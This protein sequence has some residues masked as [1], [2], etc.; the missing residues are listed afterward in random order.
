[1]N[2]NFGSSSHSNWE[3]LTSSKLED[4]WAER[5]RENEESDEEY[6]AWRNTT[7]MV[8]MACEET[9]QQPQWDD[10]VVVCSY[11]PR[12]REI[13]YETLM[14]NYLNTNTVYPEE[15]F[16]RRFR[17]RGR[18]FEHLLHNVQHVNPYFWQK[19]D[20]AC[21]P[22]FSHHQKITVALQMMLYASPADV[23]DDRWYV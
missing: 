17:M 11:K 10:P 23:I 2:S 7:F 9:Q 14:N 3:S 6:E 5:R 8:T 15:D 4:K 16:R 21:C 13:A 22:G 19:I 12:Q 20:R 1:M 18:A